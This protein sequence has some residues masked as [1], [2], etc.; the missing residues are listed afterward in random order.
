MAAT[1]YDDVP[2]RP[3]RKPTKQFH[4]IPSIDIKTRLTSGKQGNGKSPCSTL[5]SDLVDRAIDAGVDQLDRCFENV[6]VGRPPALL[7]RNGLLGRLEGLEGR[8]GLT[9]GCGCG[10][11]QE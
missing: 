7:R 4:P 6:K 2:A 8:H 1:Q 10:V 11:R 5:P 3:Q 9:R